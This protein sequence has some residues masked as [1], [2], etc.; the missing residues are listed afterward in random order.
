[1][2]VNWGRGKSSEVEGG[3]HN[4]NTELLYGRLLNHMWRS[5]RQVPAD[6]SVGKRW[7]SVG[8]FYGVQQTIAT[9]RCLVA[10]VLDNFHARCMRVTSAGIY[11]PSQRRMLLNIVDILE[12]QG[13]SPFGCHPFSEGSPLSNSVSI[14]DMSRT[15]WLT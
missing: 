7:D 3:V 5:T 6:F 15:R 9:L 14:Q 1:M 8:K 2:E 13:L 4:N 12:P 11:S 10:V